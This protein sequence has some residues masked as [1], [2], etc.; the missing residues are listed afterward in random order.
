LRFLITILFLAI[1]QLTTFAGYGNVENC[2]AVTFN[3]GKGSSTENL[4]FNSYAS[5][6]KYA[7]ECNNPLLVKSSLLNH[8]Y[9]LHPS[10]CYSSTAQK[11]G[12]GFL[13]ALFVSFYSFINNSNTFTG[14]ARANNFYSLQHN[15]KIIYPYHS[16]W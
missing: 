6:F 2:N 10:S 4:G 5:H 1:F 13:D 16:F 3:N 15:L 8:Y 9:L 12:Q 11:D 7:K 14:Y